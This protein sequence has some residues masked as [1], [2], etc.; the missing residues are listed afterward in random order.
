MLCDFGES[1]RLIFT[2][3]V[4]NYTSTTPA[5]KLSD[6]NPGQFFYNLMQ[7]NDGDPGVTTY[8][9]EIPYP[10]VT[11]GAMPVHVYDSVYAYS[12]GG[13]TCFNPMDGMAYPHVITLA[14]YDRTNPNFVDKNNDGEVGFGDAILVDVEA[15]GGFQYINIHLDYG[16]EKTDGWLK[17]G[18]NAT[19]DGTGKNPAPAGLSIVDN[20]PYTF[21]ANADGVWIVGSTDTIYNVNEFKQIRGFGGLV[22]YQTGWD[23][24]GNPVYSPLEGAQVVLT[25]PKVT[26]TM[27]TDKD[28]WYL[29]NFVHNGKVTVYTLELQAG[30]DPNGASYPAQTVTVTVGG[31]VKYGEGS[32]WIPPMP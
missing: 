9:L 8:T 25:G 30:T 3:D 23:G 20:S 2:P 28:G 26:E 6:S 1:F 14:D 19:S 12:E 21:K 31:A 10:F 5:Y 24:D 4:K 29:S 16:L 18:A 15:Q 7:V 13:Y 22:Y 32:F 17:K 27:T 11:Q